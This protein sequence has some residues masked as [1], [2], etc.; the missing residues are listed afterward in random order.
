MTYAWRVGTSI[1][2]RAWRAINSATAIGRLGARGIAAR[3]RLEGRWVTTIV[4]SSP[5]RRA[6]TGATRNDPAW[7]NPTKKKITPRVAGEAPSLLLNQK[8]MKLWTTNPP[9]KE[10]TP[11]SIAMART[12]LRD[13]PRGARP[14]ARPASTP[15]ESVPATKNPTT[16]TGTN[17]ANHLPAAGAPAPHR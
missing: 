12:R 8:A 17:R 9:P 15:F 1:W 2:D 3:S 16:P 6:I 4:G 14:D 7:S 11:N 5:K 10:S 13:G